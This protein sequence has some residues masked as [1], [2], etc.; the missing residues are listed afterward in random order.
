MVT[1]LVF[2]SCRELDLLRSSEEDEVKTCIGMNN[3]S[4]PAREK[5]R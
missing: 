3:L 2:F 5:E 4:S 1:G